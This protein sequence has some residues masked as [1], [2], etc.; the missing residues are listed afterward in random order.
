MAASYW[1]PDWFLTGWFPPVWFA[2]ADES[3]VPEGELR[4]EYGGGGPDASDDDRGEERSRF[5]H[6]KAPHE[7]YIERIKAEFAASLAAPELLQEQTEVAKP[8]ATNYDARVGP[9]SPIGNTSQ[10]IEPKAPTLNDVESSIRIANDSLATISKAA[11]MAARRKQDGE[12]AAM[13]IALLML[14]DD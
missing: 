3:G 1:Q 7:A 4:T 5:P 12:A 8:I 10:V 13:A 11:T 6:L 9:R 14:D 2:P